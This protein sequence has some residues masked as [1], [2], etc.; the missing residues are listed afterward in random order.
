MK[1]RMR[2]VFPE[3]IGFER[4]ELIGERGKFTL[5]TVSQIT[6]VLRVNGVTKWVPRMDYKYVSI[7]RQEMEISRIGSE[8]RLTYRRRKCVFLVGRRRD[9]IT[10][11]HLLCIIKGGI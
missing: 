1:Y 3:E 9:W 10:A 2:T 6:C 7:C 4:K 11:A 8:V 5:H